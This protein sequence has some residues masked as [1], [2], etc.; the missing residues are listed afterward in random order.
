MAEAT[1]RRP[2]ESTASSSKETGKTRLDAF[3]FW[4]FNIEMQSTDI[5][6]NRAT[7]QTTKVTELNEIRAAYKLSRKEVRNR[8]YIYFDPMAEHIRSVAENT[9]GVKTLVNVLDSIES[10]PPSQRVTISTAFAKVID[11]ADP[12][13]FKKSRRQTTKTV[14]QLADIFKDIASKADSEIVLAAFLR[15]LNRKPPLM[16]KEIPLYLKAFSEKQAGYVAK[17]KKDNGL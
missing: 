6:K 1:L 13:S 10:F 11:A 17:Y 15:G 9:K 5:S 14:N 16:A 4:K 2:R 7:P 12:Q 8:S 3:I